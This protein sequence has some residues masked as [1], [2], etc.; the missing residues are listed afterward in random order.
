MY[1]YM[2]IYIYIYIYVCIGMYRG[3]SKKLKT[4]FKMFRRKP[5]SVIYVYIFKYQILTSHFLM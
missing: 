3:C 5:S 2:Y 1:I 4:F